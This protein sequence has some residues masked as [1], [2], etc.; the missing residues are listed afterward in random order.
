MLQTRHLISP[1]DISVKE[2]D[3]IIE[4]AQ[5]IIKTP[6]SYADY[7]KGQIL[8]TLFYEPSTRTRFSFEAA[9]LRLGGNV[10][11]FSDPDS[12]SAKKGESIIDT[13]KVISI[14]ADI[15]V[16]RHPKEGAPYLA[17]KFAESLLDMI[18]DK[19]SVDLLYAQHITCLPQCYFWAGFLKNC[20]AHAL[21]NSFKI[22]AIRTYMP[23]CACLK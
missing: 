10:M 16:M 5:K 21:P 18:N 3:E 19:A 12:I 20:P 9:M 6:V 7:C 22:R 2:I 15:A 13:I 1:D 11:G 8:A 14:Y 4:L 17:S 23:Y